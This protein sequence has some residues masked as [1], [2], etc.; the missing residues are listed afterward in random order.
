MTGESS[1][2]D[3]QSTTLEM[4]AVHS[5]NNS[6]LRPPPTVDGVVF[7][8]QT[9][10]GDSQQPNGGRLPIAEV[11]ET[12]NGNVGSDTDQVY[13]AAAAAAAA[14][15]DEPKSP[16]GG[17][18]ING[19]KQTPLPI[20]VQPSTNGPKADHANA[21]RYSSQRENSMQKQSHHLDNGATR[22]SS[23]HMEGEVK[24]IA[25]KST[26]QSIEVR[27]TSA[28]CHTGPDSPSP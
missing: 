20:I 2:T 19:G 11:E 3:L 23:Q 16:E 17:A 6:S 7:T 4:G 26:A 9:G 25:S 14:Q 13:A 1:T 27:T 12:G 28:H 21:N 15:T 22:R 18:H 8:P 10:G 24:V 5:N